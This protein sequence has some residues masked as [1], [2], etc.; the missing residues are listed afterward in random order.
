MLCLSSRIARYCTSRG[1]R[2]G[3]VLILALAWIVFVV[4]VVARGVE[5]S[6]RLSTLIHLFFFPS[7]FLRA[8]SVFRTMLFLKPSSVELRNLS[9]FSRVHVETLESPVR[10][11]SPRFLFFRRHKATRFLLSLSRNDSIDERE[12]PGTTIIG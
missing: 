6:L 5:H 3:T 10:L 7:F 8:L 12:G 9:P 1:H 11:E 2:V 4:V